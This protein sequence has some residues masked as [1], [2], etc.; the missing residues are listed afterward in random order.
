MEMALC[1]YDYGANDSEAVEKIAIDGKG[2]Y[3]RCNIVE[4]LTK[5]QAVGEGRLKEL[6]EDQIK[7]ASETK[8]SLFDTIP[9]KNIVASVYA[10][11]NNSDIT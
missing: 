8:I 3:C 1:C 10:D 2:Y 11:P 7:T 5:S 4:G 9:L 6:I